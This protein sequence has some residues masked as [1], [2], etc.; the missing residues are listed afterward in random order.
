MKTLTEDYK[1]DENWCEQFLS[2][3]S[4]LNILVNSLHAYLN[5]QIFK[6]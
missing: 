1:A 3:I 4:Y 2:G 6:I 5:G